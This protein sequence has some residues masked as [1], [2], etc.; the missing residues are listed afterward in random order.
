LRGACARVL[1]LV[2]GSLAA[3]ALAELGSRWLRPI[4]LHTLIAADGGVLHAGDGGVQHGWLAP[5]TAYRQVS[6]EYDARTTITAEGY[7][8]PA[9][10]GPLD[11]VFLGDSFTFGSG[12][13]DDETFAWRFCQASG[14]SCANLAE[15]G[16]GTLRQVARLRE[17]LD[18]HGWRPREVML[19]VFAM[20]ASFSAGNDLEDNY[21]GE[22]GP[23]NAA[24]SAQ[25]GALER[26]LFFRGALERRS[27]L[28][29]V[30]KY[31]FGPLL[32]SALVPGLD[33]ARR[34]LALE[35]TRGALEEL[36]R[37]ARS[38]AFELT[39]YLIHP[40]QDL[41]RG[42]HPQ[43]LAALAAIAPV[44]VRS[45]APLFADDPSRYYFPL[46]GHLNPAGAEAIA[47]L[48]IAER[49]SRPA[50]R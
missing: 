15:P 4:R 50:V 35:R 37:L 20:S 26:L 10:T 47:Q 32:R 1:L 11:V 12:L 36:A 9:P 5:G 38:H 18:G 23:S 31:Y 49:R 29:R 3:L 39:I 21:L 33:D 34:Q 40:V 6:S 7:R 17:F 16:S 28:V 2:A 24:R 30:A 8:G 48:L 44:E 45:T 43:T 25:G 27:N 19:F 42:T 46:D 14:L 41:R 13:A 22:S